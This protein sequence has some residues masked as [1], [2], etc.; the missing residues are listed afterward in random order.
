MSHRFCRS[1]AMAGALA[2]AAMSYPA[3]AQTVTNERD[4]PPLRLGQKVQVDDG[5]CPAGQIKEVVGSSLTDA[6]ITRT[7]KCV[8]RLQ[9]R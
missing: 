9:R 7:S 8:P 1:A 4:I 5:S 6:G 3:A 2:L